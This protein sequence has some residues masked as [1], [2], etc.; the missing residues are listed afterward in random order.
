MKIYLEIDYQSRGI[1]RCVDAL[2]RYK[3]GNITIVDREQDA[4]MVLI[5]VNGRRD[6]VLRRTRRILERGQKYAI[7]QY[8]FRSTRNPT[9]YEWGEIWDNAAVVF[10]YLDL[11]GNEAIP[12][13]LYPDFIYVSL[14][15]GVDTEVF[16]R[17]GMDDRPWNNRKYLIC[18][19]GLGYT[20]ESVR[21][22]IHAARAV[23]GKVA[24]LGCDL[25]IEDVDSYWDLS[26]AE[27]CL[28]FNDCKYVSGLRRTEGFELPILEGFFCGAQPITFDTL[29]YRRW[30]DGIAL[31]IEE[32]DR[33]SVILQL[34]KLF[35]LRKRLLFED[36]NF[37]TKKR[38][39]RERRA[40]A[41]DFSW[42]KFADTI[43]NNLHV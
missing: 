18:T 9:Y 17:Y 27:V 3:P 1:G 12:A 42:E 15:L 13:G 22:C 33:N 26:D 41:A 20:T 30:F 43:F 5:H 36:E 40:I 38:R 35:N 7:F 29:A 10:S 6:Q 25:G 28:L 21:E 37:F 16:Y 32:G 24:H 4:D 14:P 31:F 8:A 23:G 39:E 34:I 11:V 19:T 2:K